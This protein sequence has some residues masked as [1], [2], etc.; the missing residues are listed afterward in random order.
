M[1]GL[2]DLLGG[3]AVADEV[4]AHLDGLDAA[5]RSRQ[6]LGLRGR[7]VRS[8]YD[9]CKG[10]VVGAAHFVPADVPDGTPV[11][12][13][14][15]N[16]MPVFRRF[17]KRFLRAAD[18]SG[19][20]WGYNHQPWYWL[21]GP[22]FFVVEPPGPGESVV[23]DYTR[24]PG[25]HP[26]PDWPKPRCNDGIPDRFT[27]GGMRDGMC[28]VSDHVSVGRAEKRGRPAPAWFVLVRR[29]GD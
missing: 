23:I 9:L 6:V 21:T 7:E 13:D 1:S 2:R 29:N 24:V 26:H 5:Q 18:G 11:H 28:L 20:V 10:R 14:G 15:L 4:A 22:G 3:A 12:H 8:L 17:E 25:H 16:S 27:W 19:E